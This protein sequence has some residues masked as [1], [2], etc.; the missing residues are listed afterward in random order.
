LDLFEVVEVAE[1]L[2][3]VEMVPVAVETFL[4]IPL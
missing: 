4:E 1:G 2:F 3:Q